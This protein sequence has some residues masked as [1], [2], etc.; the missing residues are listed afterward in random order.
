LNLSQEGE[1]K[2]MTTFPVNFPVSREFSAETQ[3][4]LP[5]VPGDVTPPERHNPQTGHDDPDPDKIGASPAESVG[6]PPAQ[7]VQ[8]AREQPFAIAELFG[9]PP[10]LKHEDR[11]A[12][13]TWKQTVQAELQPRDLIEALWARDVVHLTWEVERGRRLKKYLLESARP[14]ATQAMVRV[15]IDEGEVDQAGLDAL[16]KKFARAAWQSDILGLDIREE[17]VTA[18]AYRQLNNVIDT[19]ERQ[20]AGWETR[21]NRILRDLEL[22]REKLEVRRWFHQLADAAQR[23]VDERW[24]EMAEKHHMARDVVETRT[25]GR[26]RGRV[27]S[28]RRVRDASRGKSGGTEPRSANSRSANLAKIGHGPPGDAS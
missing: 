18:Q 23:F 1:N 7:T 14:E 16:A 5:S 27:G 11:D 4:D 3:T 2:K 26:R 10:L 12:Y 9:R 19:L 25:T 20:I 6:K 24:A 22:R 8:S 15:R 17:D 28:T 21:R 13:E